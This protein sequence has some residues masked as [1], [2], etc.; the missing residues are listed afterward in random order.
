MVCKLTV[1]KPTDTRNVTLRLNPGTKIQAI[2]DRDEISEESYCNYELN[3]RYR[4]QIIESGL[5]CSGW[6][7]EVVQAREQ[8]FRDEG[9][10]LGIL[11]LAAGGE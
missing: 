8:R 5:I 11:G 9:A 4:E 10:P 3:N 1:N 7:G 2:Y 6:E